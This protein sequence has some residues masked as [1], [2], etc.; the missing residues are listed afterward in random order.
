VLFVGSDAAAT[1]RAGGAAYS[2]SKAASEMLWRCLAT[3]LGEEIAF[4]IAKPGL[5]ETAM[6][7][8]SL[9]A[10]RAEFP[11]GEVYAAMRARGETIAAHTVAR[12][13]RFLLLETTREEFASEVWD[14]RK[15]EHHPR[16][17]THP[18]YVPPPGS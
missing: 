1:P 18:L 4:G 14:I 7:E 2:V 12:F 10:P 13:F 3:E 9:R 6:L 15:E 17:L 11:A 5:V 8:E 16:W